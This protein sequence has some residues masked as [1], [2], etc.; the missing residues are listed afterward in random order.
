MEESLLQKLKRL[1]LNGGDELPVAGVNSKFPGTDTTLGD[2]TSNQ[3]LGINPVLG[4]AAKGANHWAKAEGEE[5][6]N[7]YDLAK[8]AEEDAALA[9]KMP[10]SA[11]AEPMGMADSLRARSGDADMRPVKGPS[12]AEIKSLTNR[13]IDQPPVESMIPTSHVIDF[14]DGG[15]NT[16]ENLRAAQEAANN[17]TLIANM[18]SAGDAFGA[19]VSN[20]KPK[21]QESVDRL[22]K[23]A[24]TPI[25][26]FKAA[27]EQEKNDANSPI[28]KGY[29]EAM[30]RFGIE[31]KGNASAAALEKVAPWMEKVYAAD[32]ARKQRAFD[33]E[34]NRLLRASISAQRADERETV[35]DARKQDKKET[36]TKDFRKEI[37]GG[38]LKTQYQNYQ[39]GRRA[40]AFIDDAIKNPNGF[41]DYG[42]LMA[43][44][45]A[46]QGDDSVVREAEIRLGASVG[47]VVDKIGAY[48]KQLSSGQKLTENQR[49]MMMNSVKTLA[50]ISQRQYEDAIQ[51]VR[52]QAKDLGID[53]KNL[54]MSNGSLTSGKL[55]AS[56]SPQA[57]SGGMIK[58]RRKTDGVTKSVDPASAK[59]F[60]SDPNYE[61][62]P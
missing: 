27:S 25:E 47:S 37:T 15:I 45:K 55:P 54:L 26:Q 17:N 53:E 28:S 1:Y 49:K 18:L 12:Q 16:V 20:T 19:A 62:V 58:I 8:I 6:Q 40:L 22:L 7:E 36:F 33:A 61:Q 59:K 29:R 52:E 43:S 5:L 56:V 3:I 23:Q 46:L 13:T 60:L 34:Q 4:L 50:D 21:A 38:A 10:A 32:Q 44:L 11:P 51:P 42:A 41:K 48:A 9:G 31:V 57:T 30:K 24:N 14:G 39:N 2:V 35:K